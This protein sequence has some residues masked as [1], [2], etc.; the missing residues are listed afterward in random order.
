MVLS[1]LQGEE[2][3]ANEGTVS[4]VLGRSATGGTTAM[5][6]VTPDLAALYLRNRDV[7]HKVAASV[8][9]EVC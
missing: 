7:M 3:E 9:R 6:N 1:R 2:D 4:M 8:L 5:G